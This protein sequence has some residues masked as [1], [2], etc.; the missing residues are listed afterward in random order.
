MTITEP[1]PAPR[2]NL[3]AITGGIGAGKSVVAR[4]VAALGYDV[5]DCDSRARALMA[6]EEITRE[7]AETFGPGIFTPAG[8][9]IRPRLAEIV[10]NDSAALDRLNAITH[11]AV[12]AD[13]DEWAAARAD[14][15]QIFVETAILY[16]SGIDRMVARVWEVTAPTDLRLERVMARSALTRDQA[17]ARIGAQDAFVPLR[18]HPAVTVLLN[19]GVTPLLPAIRHILNLT[20]GR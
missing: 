7:L 12:R 11:S 8:E 3:T 9:L 19:D 18:P 16:Q 6:G 1:S 13:L 14:A 15:S 4:I 5:Y 20:E 10:F 17:L 2:P